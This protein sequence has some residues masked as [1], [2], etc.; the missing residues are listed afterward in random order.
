VLDI[1]SASPYHFLTRARGGAKTADLAGMAHCGDARAGA[2]RRKVV[3]ARL[4]IATRASS[5]IDSVI[6][7]AH[8]R[9]C[10]RAALEIGGLPDQRTAP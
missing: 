4:P 1:G 3:R 2:A 9:R 10:C 7:T 5:L 6:A 8:G